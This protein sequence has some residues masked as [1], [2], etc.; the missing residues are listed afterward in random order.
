MGTPLHVRVKLCAIGLALL[1]VIA[2]LDRVV[3]RAEAQ[4]TGASCGDPLRLAR[5]VV[6]I[7]WQYGQPR[8]DGSQE[9]VGE[10]ATAWFYASPR[11]LVTA[12]HFAK[13]LPAE[14][15]QE[16]EL[17]QSSREGE[18]A[19]AVQ[20]RLRVTVQGKI[21]EGD[22]GG[23]GRDVRMAEDLAILELQE[24]FQDAQILEVQPEA[25]SDNATVLILG[26]PKGQMKAALGTIRG[27]EGAASRYPGLALLEVQGS[28]RLLLNGGASG[29]PVLDCKGRVVAVLNG[30]LTGPSLP[31][32]PPERSVIPTPWGSPTNTA[33]PVRML[34]SIRNRML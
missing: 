32:L 2:N 30:L 19:V 1:P 12:A 28:D 8:R 6:S 26:Y 33:V 20:V 22:A 11:F 14:G 9:I 24:P 29:A 7:V 21:S 3:S 25:P 13:E 18:P 17:R 31:F 27:T 10:R 16:V 5:S 34:E 15:W 4:E 23:R